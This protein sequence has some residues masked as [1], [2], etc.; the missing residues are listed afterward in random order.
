MGLVDGTP[1]NSGCRHADVLEEMGLA[2]GLLVPPISLGRKNPVKAGAGC[3]R[4]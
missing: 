4:H 2:L 3:F 1:P